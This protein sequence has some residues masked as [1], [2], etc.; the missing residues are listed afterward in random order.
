M[1][2]TLAVAGAIQGAALLAAAGAAAVVLLSTDRRRRAAAM[3]A[4]LVLALAAVATLAGD[5]LDRHAAAAGG[6]AAAGLVAIAVLAM[7][8]LRRPAALG[9]MA[10]AAIPFRVP[11]AIGDDTASLLVPL[12]AVIAAA[13]LA[14]AVRWLGRGGAERAQAAGPD[15]PGRR[16]RRLERALAAVL[17]LYA[18]Q[19]TYSTDLE[20]AVKN[21][22]LFYVPFALLFRLLLDVRWSR[23]LLLRT[24]YV[25]VG[26]ALVFAGV[27][28]FEYAT[29]RL[30]L[31]NE[32]V[33]DANDLKPYFRVN[34]LFFD[35]NI[36]GRFLALAMIAITAALLWTRRRRDT[37]L[38]AAALAVLWAGLVLSLS[39]SSF[40]AL[41]VGLAVLAALRWR[42]WP[43]LAASGGAAAVAVAV[44][45]LA[46]GA[47]SLD[48][49]SDDALDRA[50]SGRVDLVKGGLEMVRERPVWGFGSG[51]FEERYRV[52][53]GVSSERVAAASH[54][55]PLT[56]AAEQ[57]VIGLA[58][59]LVLLWAAL[60]LVFAG[61]SSRREEPPEAIHTVARAAVAA[62]FCGLVVHT[63]VYAAFL[64]DPLTWALL[65]M[66]AALRA[67]PGPSGE[68][69]TLH[70]WP[71]RS[72]ARASS[73]G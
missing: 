57:G 22:A 23:R 10:V 66:A 17:V 73:G 59:Y 16:L 13:A 43:V 27:A 6:V 4:A 61:P 68:A 54:T 51:S 42:V 28:F 18:L 31:V 38:L 37:A 47:L 12:Y 35:P 44:V 40:A 9:M 36:Y 15:V 71:I 62:A 65:A 70:W 41:L 46:P 67:P 45:L 34:S 39:Q 72:A 1:P 7:V 30:L 26:L 64:E 2:Q 60:G 3:I 52:R 19:A 20:Q 21:V 25:A 56:V 63:L 29:G 69:P 58:A 50:T 33:Q 14:Q 11:V 5:E 32:K 55:I 48:T 49:G 53:E 24:F 8:I